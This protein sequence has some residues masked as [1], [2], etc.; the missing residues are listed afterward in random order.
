MIYPPAE[1]RRL[2]ENRATGMTDD[3]N[4]VAKRHDMKHHLM[5]EYRH[6]A[7]ALRYR[8]GGRDFDEI[9]ELPA[10]A[11]YAIRRRQVAPYD[12]YIREHRLAMRCINTNARAPKHGRAL[13]VLTEMS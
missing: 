7:D 4:Q 5:N 13:S 9:A 6:R 1:A 3:A 2:V 10:V 12:A 8:L 11:A